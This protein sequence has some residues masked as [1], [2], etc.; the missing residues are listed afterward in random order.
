[1]PQTRLDRIL[2]T[3][4]AG[5]VGRKLA[6]KL[7]A[8]WPDAE[9]ILTD[10]PQAAA[11]LEGCYA[12]D[13]TDAVAIDQLIRDRSP[14][15]IIHLAAVSAISN[16]VDDQRK[17]W[18]VNTGGTLNIVMAT[19]AHR[20][21]CHLVYIS[22][23]EVY[24]RTAFSGEP[25]N[26]GALLRPANPY[27]VTKAAADLMV[28]EATDRGLKATV[29]RPFNHTGPGQADLF[30]IPSFC[31]QIAKIEAGLQDPVIL[32]GELNDFRDF[33]DV[34][35]VV[36]VYAR[37]LDRGDHLDNGTVLNVSSG[38]PRKIGDLLGTLV[39]ASTASIEIRV[40]PERLRRTR[41]PK[42]IGDSQKARHL[43]DWAPARQ[44]EKTLLDTL[45]YWRV[46]V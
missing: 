24:G 30:A 9:I 39:A 20:P 16:S 43:L 33:L 35:D 36:D 44:F 19:T 23:A 10:H 7:A 2:V 45:N 1:M 29:L 42:I 40:D 12:L 37:V 13:I 46:R 5:F 38:I 27:A 17:T 11:G 32:V 34:D 15:A 21:D 41:V 6:G 14:D 31:H 25:V 8:S 26:E 22:S 4:A 3:G 18:L 28:Q